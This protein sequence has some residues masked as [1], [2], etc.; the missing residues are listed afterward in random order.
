M[1]HN[2]GIPHRTLRVH[3]L[4]AELKAKIIRCFE[5][6]KKFIGKDWCEN[7]ANETYNMD[8]KGCHPNFYQ[9]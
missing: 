5:Q 4:E 9:H 8:E 1:W 6:F 7:K 3:E 2:I